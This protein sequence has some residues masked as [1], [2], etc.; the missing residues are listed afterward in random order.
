MLRSMS[1]NIGMAFIGFAMVTIFAFAGCGDEF[2]Y[3]DQSELPVNDN[4]MKMLDEIYLIDCT[5]ISIV[6]GAASTVT[7]SCGGASSAERD[8][9]CEAASNFLREC[10][11]A[12]G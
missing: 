9:C 3:Q 8:A 7:T 4:A 1:Q 12:C 2:G 5:C 10:H 11:S 6:T